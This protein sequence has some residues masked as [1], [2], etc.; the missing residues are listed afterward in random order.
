M[1]ECVTSLQCGLA[2]RR[3][4]KLSCRRIMMKIT[5]ILS[6]SGVL[7]VSTLGAIGAD[8]VAPAEG[9]VPFRRDKI[10]LEIDQMA[11]LSNQLESLVQGLEPTDIVHRRAAAQMLALAM[12]LDP[13]NTSARE[14]V[15]D[16]QLGNSP[17]SAP[18][19]E[20]QEAQK[21]VWQI[22][23]WLSSAEAGENA[24]TLARCLKDV[25]AISDPQHLGAQA[26]QDLKEAG[27]WSGW[28]ADLAAFAKKEAPPEEIPQ[29]AIEPLKEMPAPAPV[30]LAS[31]ELPTVL[32]LIPDLENA[33]GV[34]QP[35][36]SRAPLKMSA[37]RS[38][39]IA[40]EVPAFSIRKESNFAAYPLG[41]MGIFTELLTLHHSL[42]PTD[43]TIT[44]GSPLFKLPQRRAG[45][46]PSRPP[47]R[48]PR[49][50]ALKPDTVDAS[51]ATLA[52]AAISGKAASAIIIGVLN[53]KGEFLPCEDF[54]NKVQTLYQNP[55][56]KNRLVVP[57]AAAPYMLAVLALEQPQFFFDYEVIS[58]SN[59]SEL[60]E[61]SA[62]K[63]G[64]ADA[65]A[66]AKFAEIRDKS[67]N[68]A[69]NQYVA[70]P[71]ISRR[72]AELATEFPQHISAKLLGLQGSGN[73]PRL[74]S[75][76]VL[77]AMLRD[78]LKPISLIVRDAESSP[79]RNA[80]QL[81]FL[82]EQYRDV[83]KITEAFV[84]KADLPL[85]V[86]AQ[87]ITV[88]LRALE[89]AARSYSRDYYGF[90]QL[91]SAQ[92]NLINAHALI[93]A[94]LGT[95]LENPVPPPATK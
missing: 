54:W 9:P 83:L 58:A 85:F 94:D 57:T 77:T 79:Y 92:Q 16:F 64:A 28:V 18:G 20:I 34:R 24:N 19:N 72:L 56:G 44:F 17:P 88:A 5:Q 73:R 76:E 15:T 13:S 7:F 45:S 42:L 80:P 75:R 2:Q 81:L 71:F 82:R 29:P 38:T 25:L 74:V 6:L 22:N 62:G 21:A 52:S 66:S 55:S 86:K 30:A 53:A 63:L 46:D 50:Q 90:E 65:A 12:A 14:F 35:A 8:F 10:P 51:A 69:I 43:L 32:W 37:A 33:Q 3:R 78:A 26:R 36:L 49:L 93:A 70:N 41:E 68:Q 61:R 48:P 23:E 1:T 27:E 89:R 47:P 31:A 87:D 84:E 91:E 11:R 60:L 39:P 59:F 4:E 40:G 95:E 67:A